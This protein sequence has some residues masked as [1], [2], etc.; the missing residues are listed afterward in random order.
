MRHLAGDDIDLVIKRHGDDHVGIL[1]TRLFQ[2]IRM[3]SVAY[4]ALHV[5]CLGDRR[6]Q[7]CGGVDH[8][9][10]VVFL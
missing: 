7:G 4:I 10:V 2:R 6:N 5:E 1:G 9:D 8:G 3:R